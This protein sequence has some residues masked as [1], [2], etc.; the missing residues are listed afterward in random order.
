[1]M[2]WKEVVLAYFKELSQHLPRE[3]K[4]KSMKN[5]RITGLPLHRHTGIYQMSPS[6][7]DG[8][9]VKLIIPPPPYC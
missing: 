1:M 6:G 4:K 8:L 5:H 9:K 7:K 3:A 2:N